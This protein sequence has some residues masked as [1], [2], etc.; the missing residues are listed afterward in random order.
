MHRFYVGSSQIE[1]E[2][3]YLE[4]IEAKHARAVLR[5]K[6]G[7]HVVLFDGTGKKVIA[8]VQEVGKNLTLKMQKRGQYKPSVKITV[9]IGLPKAAKMDKIVRQLTELGVVSINP[10]I[11]EFG[12][13]REV[14]SNVKLE[15]WKR[16]AIEACKQSGNLIIPQTHKPIVL[17]E[18][19][20]KI[21]DH[22]KAYL[23][24]EGSKEL[25]K[26]KKSQSIAVIIGPEGG[27]SKADLDLFKPLPNIQTASLGDTILRVETAAVA[28]V[29]IV[30]ALK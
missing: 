25:I 4:G 11:S 24:Y 9:F 16:I 2:I 30:K 21:A 8:Q 19:L 18:L 7:E 17:K 23:F 5:I 3:I 20:G 10:F 29:S 22:D 13:V 26:P 12:T 14:I 28:A 27:F 15:R 1:N 6:E